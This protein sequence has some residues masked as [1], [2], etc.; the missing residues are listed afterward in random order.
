[1]SLS[2]SD[3]LIKYHLP[4]EDIFNTYPAVS[5]NQSILDKEE[6][7]ELK[8]DKYE[9]IPKEKGGLLKS[10]LI[11]QRLLSSYTPYDELLLFHEVGTG[12]TCSSVG[13]IENCRQE[14][15]GFRGALILVSGAPLIDNYVNELVFTC[16]DGRYI[17]KD[18]ESLTKT[19]R[20]IRS[21]KAVS[22][23]YHFDTFQMFAKRINDMTDDAIR[24][25]YEGYV[26]FVDEV[27][28]LSPSEEEGGVNT[29]K[30]LHRFLHLLKNRKI[31][32]AS[33]TP[34][35]DQPNEIANVMNL[36]LPLDKQMPTGEEFNREFMYETEDDYLFVRANKES[37]LADYFA[38]RVSYLKVA[39]SDVKKE[40]V[41]GLHFGMKHFITYPVDMG[42]EQ[43]KG[44][45][46]AFELDSSKE[47]K[48]GIYPNSRQATLFVF[49]DGSWGKDGFKKWI[50]KEKKPIIGETNK[51]VTKYSF[52]PEFNQLF[53]GKSTEDKLNTLSNFSSKYAYIIRQ[54]LFSPNENFFVYIDRVEGSGAILFSL[55]LRKFGF[56]PAKGGEKTKG[57]RYAL[58]TGQTSTSSQIKDLVKTFNQ[59]ENKNGGIIKVII[60]SSV[61]SEGLSFKNVQQIHIATPHWN[62]SETDQAI[63]R[64][65]RLF[66]HKDLGKDVVVKIFQLVSKSLTKKAASIDA[67]MYKYSEEK[68]VS[69]KNVER[70]VK[71]AAIDCQLTKAR[72]T[73]TGNG[74]R[75]CD[76]MSCKY[77]C[78]NVDTDDVDMDYSSYN[79]LYSGKKVSIIA[80]EI[81]R[82]LKEE[83]RI[84]LT[85]LQERF[86]SFTE[87]EIVAAIKLLVDEEKSGRYNKNGLLGWVREDNGVIYL[88]PEYKSESTMFDNAYI[89]SLYLTETRSM[90]SLSDSLYQNNLPK[91]ID[92]IVNMTNEDD[93]R[94][95]VFELPLEVQVM[96][97]ETAVIAERKKIKV[98]ESFRK[99][100]LSVFKTFLRKY[101]NTTVHSL[102]LDKGMLKCLDEG[103]E[104]WKDC[105][106][107]LE[108]KMKDQEKKDDELYERN[109]YGY[110]G[111]FN[112][113]TGEFQIRDVSNVEA[114]A[115]ARKSART[116]G[117]N[118]NTISRS[119]LVK[120]AD[121]LSVDFDKSFLD[122]DRDE[123]IDLTKTTKYKNTSLAFPDAVLKKMP[124]E[125]L[126]RAVYWGGKNKEAL[127]PVLKDWFE[128]HDLLKVVS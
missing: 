108:S 38:G 116:K 30:A 24:R 60:G 118:C 8:L 62:Y 52:T 20:T 64:G 100:L 51:F 68:D 85:D 91:V 14:N 84:S 79:T 58:L 69:N 10:Q 61:V 90:S 95:L 57:L 112:T 32:I 4:G 65:I 115:A 16:T 121:A 37:D 71:R 46:K 47:K 117:R 9:S 25:D 31:M 81:F 123:L 43:Q 11:V 42:E 35:K 63:G 111:I 50:I 76:Y 44:Y 88:T 13:V 96:L 110:Y 106:A 19:E 26:V 93:I 22:D 105:P 12:K 125:R 74:T 98:G 34:M 94:K 126:A 127:C 102:L 55:I 27:H 120:I 23:F 2:L 114:I 33:A 39:P 124:I 29:Y 80:G 40:F 92:R 97:L 83:S 3:F 70:V 41:G 113:S 128:A 119:N 82:I 49:P 59:P 54:L 104:K 103:K 122:M 72:N 45:N 5:L 56:G 67:T 89:S 75:G 77:S 48:Q 86:T 15:F 17:P 53:D 73:R 99:K 7:S 66:S 6:F 28:N 107:D 109:D 87:Y 21:K 36:I 18:Y 1:M 101:G 78:D